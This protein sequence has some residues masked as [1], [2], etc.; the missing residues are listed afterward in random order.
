MKKPF[1]LV[2]FSIAL[3]LGLCIVSAFAE[4]GPETNRLTVRMGTFYVKEGEKNMPLV[5]KATHTIRKGKRIYIPVT[6]ENV[7]KAKSDAVILR[8]MEKSG[9]KDASRE[10]RIYRVPALDPGKKWERA[11]TARY[12]ESGRKEISLSLTTLE[13]NPLVDAKGKRLPDTEYRDGV[14]LQIKDF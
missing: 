11:F 3:S 13:G 1:L 12:E 10:P 4:T 6:V 2:V 8:Y 7:G 5:G 14:H 9:R